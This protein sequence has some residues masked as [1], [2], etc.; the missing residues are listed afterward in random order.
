MSFRP[1]LWPLVPLYRLAVRLREFRLRRGWEPVRQ[2]DWPV[3]SI[4]NLSA[5]GA[6]KTP[7]AIALVRALQ[8]Q[9]VAVDVLSRGYGRKSTAAVQVDA[10]GP[11]EEFGDEPLLIARATA[12]P[13]F[14]AGQR[15]EA[16][17]LAELDQ[18]QKKIH[19][20]DD[21]FQHRQLHRAVDLLLVSGR[22]LADSLLPAGNLR[23]PLSALHRAS[24]LVIPV[25]E[26]ETAAA[27]RSRGWQGPIWRIRR[28]MQVPAIKGPVVAFCG[29]ARPEQFFSGLVQAGVQLAV[30]RAY[31]DH[32]CYTESDGAALATLAAKHKATLL[33]TE[34]D[35]ARLGVLTDALHGLKTAPLVTEIEGEAACVE[36]LIACL[37]VEL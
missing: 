9:G 31:A 32:H 15:Y 18:N 29:I 30:H 2:L 21:G 7:L 23:E 36:W 27:L 33:T 4:G 22:D 28:R 35:A 19:L 37:G 34:K 16:G 5:G 3:V 10:Q 8:K 1:L 11:A 26:P 17:L 14:V 6:G 13:V 24:V 12:A 20:L 25:E